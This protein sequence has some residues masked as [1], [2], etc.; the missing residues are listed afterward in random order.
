MVTKS[1]VA[2]EAEMRACAASLGLKIWHGV[3]PRANRKLGRNVMTETFKFYGRNGV[4]AIAYDVLTA[5]K[6]VRQM[7]NDRARATTN[8]SAPKKNPVPLSSIAKKSLTDDAK[9]IYSKFTGHDADVVGKLK[10]PIVPDALAVIGDCAGIMYDTIRDGVK[11]KYIHKFHSNS[12]PLFCVSP[13][14]KS[15]WLLGGEFTFTERGIVDENSQ[16]RAI[17]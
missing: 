13:D 14:G 4:I 2:I 6:R 8:A 16:G 7:C 3:T 10:K 5:A 15:L 11:E 1:R 17:E 12:R 9:T